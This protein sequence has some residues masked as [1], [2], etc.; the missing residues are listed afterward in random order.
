M[1]KCSKCNLLKPLDEFGNNKNKKD[2]KQR[3]CK[4][5]QANFDHNFYL[6]NKKEAKERRKQYKQNISD[7]LEQYKKQSECKKCKEKRWYT[8]QFHHI[9]SF[10]K[11]F[12]IS[13][14]RGTSIKK[15]K[16]EIKKCEILCSN[17]HIEFHH[18]E[19]KNQ[20][21]FKDYIEM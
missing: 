15:I 12:N 1:K 21:T 6:K 7:W 13:D 2:K 11:D 8:L 16:E 3:Y 9:N 10:E 14:L 5:C 4:K 19:R 18:L 17:C 20:T